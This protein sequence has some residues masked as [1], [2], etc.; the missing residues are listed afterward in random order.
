MT[1]TVSEKEKTALAALD[2]AGVE[3]V[4]ISHPHA[5]T[6]ELCEGIGAEFGASHCKNLFLTNKAGTRFCLL[7][8]DA[9]K[10]FRTSD[11]SRRLGVTRMSFASPEQLRSVLGAEQGAVSAMALIN[12]CAAKAY[13]D[14]A[15]R[16]V[17][18]RDII[19][20][21]KLCVHPNVDTA[22][23]VLSTSELLRFIKSRGMDFSVLD[24]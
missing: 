14:G 18:D 21:G 24:V 15:L 22:T 16:I 12:D 20:R 2:A 17:I 11:V 7:L 5:S 10:P 9:D 4:R 19:E 8:M 23:L 13:S 3:Y 6:M 1:G